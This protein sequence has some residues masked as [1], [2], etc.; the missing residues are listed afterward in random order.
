MA[1]TRSST[2]SIEPI[3]HRA[4][5][6]ESPQTKI[7][8]TERIGGLEQQ[9]KEV[10]SFFKNSFHQYLF[11]LLIALSQMSVSSGIGT[12]ALIIQ[13][14]KESLGVE[15]QAE[16]SWWVLSL[17]PFLYL[18]ALWLWE[19]VLIDNISPNHQVSG[20]LQSYKW[21]IRACVGVSRK[22]PRLQKS[23][24]LWMGLVRNL[25]SCFSAVQFANRLRFLTR[26]AGIGVA[27]Q[28]PNGLALLGL[29][30]PPH[31][32]AKNVAY[33]ITGFLAPSGYNFGGLIGSLFI[34]L[35]GSWR[36]S[37]YFYLVFCEVVAILSFFFIP[38]S[39]GLPDLSLTL[40][41][42]LSTF[43]YIGSF[44]GCGALLLFSVAWN[45]AGVVGWPSPVTYILLIISLVVFLPAFIYS[46]TKVKYP[47]MPLSVWK[48]KGMVQLFSAMLFG[49]G[50]FGIY[51]YYTTTFILIFR[52][53]LL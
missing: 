13:E 30:F 37:F 6:D 26:M 51:L 7:Q 10:E 48:R 29:A 40:K 42:R 21:Y 20:R 38:S 44:F 22:Y 23:L 2:L 19:G 12:P 15:S 34:R 16:A 8:E 1:S 45:Q 31:S 4:S 27:L 9:S 18:K 52:R 46:Q 39:I 35:N 50:S 28:V 24:C 5:D 17:S 49:W 53:S 11:V 33:A 25:E 32:K 3:S 47:I 43:D 36:G 14:I 41:Q